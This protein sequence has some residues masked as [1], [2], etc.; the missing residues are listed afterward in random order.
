MTD[1]T[2]FT[3][4]LTRATPADRAAYL[5]VACGADAD[6]RRRVE[7]LLAAHDSPGVLDHPPIET[8]GLGINPAAA[9]PPRH[10][11]PGEAPG[12]VIGR[13]RLLQE[14]G[15][16]GFGTVWMAEQREPVRRRVALKVIKL[17]MDTRQVVARFEAERQALALMDH[18]NIARVLDA[19]ATDT[20]RP[21][22][23]MELVKG[24]PITEYCDTNN[25]TTGERLRLFVK[26]CQAIQHA[27]QKGV[28]HRDVKPS[29]V[30]VTLHDGVPVPKV[31]DFG[32]AKATNAELTEKTLFT[33]FKQMVGTPAY[34]S[35][36]QAEMSGLDIDTRSDIYSLGVLL[37]ELLTGTTPFDPRELMR[38]G[39]G[40]I[41][42]IIREQEPPR[43]STRVS[44]LG[45]QSAD[46]ARHRGTD[47]RR[48]STSIRGDLD[49]IVMKAMEKDR[50]RRYETANGLAQD[51]A[52]HLADEPVVARPAA[53]AY[54]FRKFVR[55]HKAGAA[56]TAAVAAALLLGIAGTTTGMFRARTAQQAAERSRGDAEDQK[57]VA[58]RLLDEVRRAKDRAD[59]ANGFMRTMFAAARGGAPTDAA[60]PAR[61]RGADARVVDVLKQAADALDRLH[62]RPE[63]ELD[64]RL[65]LAKTY[66]AL[67]MMP[68]A[69]AHYD[70][71]RTLSRA[72]TGD[73][74]E[75]TLQITVDFLF[76]SSAAAAEPL[77]RQTAQ[78]A[79]RRFGAAH[80]LT[81]DA[82]NSLALTLRAAGQLRPAH[83]LLDG[84]VRRARADRRTHHPKGT[85]RYYA[86]LALLLREL[87]RPAEAD[88]L[89]R[90]AAAIAAAEP[91]TDPRRSILFRTALVDQLRRDDKP[92]EAAAALRALLDDARNSLGDTHPATLACLA[93]LAEL[94]SLLG[95][96]DDAVAHRARLLATMD[97]GSQDRPTR[98]TVRFAHAQALYRA[99]RAG[100]ARAACDAA[101]KEIRDVVRADPD[102]AELL[103]Y[104][105]T[106]RELLFGARDDRPWAG[107]AVRAFFDV[108]AR[109]AIAPH[110]LRDPPPAVRWDDLRFRIDHWAGGDAAAAAP[111]PTHG[112]FD[113]L[114][115]APDP[116]AGVHLLSLAI[117][118]DGTFPVHRGQWMLVADWDVT[119]HRAPGPAPTTDE[120]WLAV[121]KTAPVERR[122]SRAIAHYAQGIAGRPFAA[123]R[124]DD[125]AAVAEADVRVPPGRY[126]LHLTHSGTCRGWVDGAK[127]YDGAAESPQAPVVEFKDDPRRIRLEAA[128]CAERLVVQL[129]P[130]HP[131]A[132]ALA[133]ATRPWPYD[134]DLELERLDAR[135]ALA[136]ADATLHFQRAAQ[137]A[138][139]ADFAAA[140]RAYEAATALNPNSLFDCY[141]YAILLA[142]L[143][144]HDAFRAHARDMLRRFRDSPEPQAGELLVKTFCALP[145]EASG[146]THDD[147]V[148]LAPLLDRSFA[149][150]RFPSWN[151]LAKGLLEYRLGRNESLSWLADAATELHD[152]PLGAVTANYFRG[153]MLW[154]A[155]QADD[156]RKWRD[157]AEAR[158]RRRD[159]FTL[160]GRDLG[161]RDYH[162]RLV[163][164]LARRAAADAFDRH[165]AGWQFITVHGGAGD[166]RADPDQ[167]PGALRL[168][169]TRTDGV[170]WH[171]RAARNRLPLEHGR[172]YVVRFKAKSAAADRPLTVYGQVA[173]GD[174][175][176]FGLGIDLKLTTNWKDYEIPFTADRPDP[177][178]AN[179]VVFSAARQTGTVWL[180][181]VTITPK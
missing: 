46:V 174:W 19:G 99:G 86:N 10:A 26:V 53:A 2:I 152:S 111:A 154:R 101:I 27:H 70:R 168:S 123:G 113:D 137:L 54:R 172:H 73:E 20:G 1:E 49:W 181:D 40:E 3:N 61:P 133:R 47:A 166:L 29:N 145:P 130:L 74:S 90:E 79:E 139:K 102:Y 93:Q 157:D 126:R 39:L 167:G 83:E 118:R 140:R 112:S 17:G 176:G 138:R 89:D 155:G 34:M 71:A 177:D 60:G 108:T 9:A 158:A 173:K 31:I 143:G 109:E 144:D 50:T 159:L 135:L 68:E 48:L 24:V 87:G 33:E 91:Q 96:W 149:A 160:E 25:L 4:A 175:R 45:E 88:P 75:Q 35:P 42:R 92:A 114:L 164:L 117:P 136:P 115:A 76:A 169:V 11:P 103:P 38:Q 67:V 82:V 119:L 80:P 22:F 23:V 95:R 84:L 107:A 153:A 85:A 178:A 12:A 163:L 21:F 41:Q 16:G 124:T 18:P 148:A 120:Q 105:V 146:F 141:Q 142:H 147:L 44:T 55:R 78:A 98:A 8:V 6:L 171:V 170:N 30:L 57:T 77:A 100:E 122:R 14:I 62:D 104:C 162:D 134:A 13:Y 179:R 128:H 127:V 65:N 132:D 97:A 43:P 151:K 150:G 36:E 161:P 110:A 58:L 64:V 66:E 81:F 121:L 56:A 165:P 131:A 72:Q 51:V 106:I 37:Y 116:P 156:A 129:E 5:A 94:D 28:I 63:L 15:H 52:R 180:K 7:D 32:I 69:A 125:W 59:A